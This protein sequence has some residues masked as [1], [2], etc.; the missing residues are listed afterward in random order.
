LEKVRL[1]NE[2]KYHTDKEIKE[3]FNIC[4]KPL[5]ITTMKV[6]VHPTEYYNGYWGCSSTWRKEVHVTTGE[7]S[8]R[9]TYPYYNNRPPR[10][11]NS[12]DRWEM[13][14]ETADHTYWR[15]KPDY[16]DRY[17]EN[18]H[19]SMLVLDRSEWIM[20][21]LAH[22]LRHQWQRKRR[23]MNDFT[24]TV[25]NK[26]RKSHFRAE[27]DCDT[28]ALRMVRKW[29]RLHAVDIYPEQPD[30]LYEQKKRDKK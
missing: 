30:Q 20:H 22:E 15:K 12:R 14:R 7:T 29:R 2:S 10:L 6:H 9:R 16:A 8:N 1:I 11:V 24:Y 25:R 5:R 3:M 21:L 13:V 23:P 26:G 4:A 17:R 28:F 27:R 18:A 19:L